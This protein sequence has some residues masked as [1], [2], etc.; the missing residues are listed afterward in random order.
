MGNLKETLATGDT[1]FL[2][3]KRG[4]KTDKIVDA[5][6]F[7]E[8]RDYFNFGLAPTVSM[9]E[10]LWRIWH[11]KPTPLE[12]VLASAQ[13]TFKS[14]TAAIST[15]YTL[16]LLSLMN[17]PH[18]ELRMSPIDEIFI[19]IQS[20]KL[21]TAEDAIYTRIQN[22]VD[23]SP[24]F[25][26]SFPRNMKLSSELHFPNNIILKPI[27]GSWNAIQSKNV[28]GGAI[29]EIN[30]MKVHKTSVELEH[31]DK[32]VWD[33]GEQAFRN[34]RNRV[35][36]RFKAIIRSGNHVGRI[37]IDSARRYLGDFT[38]RKTEEAKKDP[39]ILVIQR[40]LWDAKP[41]DY[42]GEEWFYVEIATDYRPARILTKLENAEQWSDE[43]LKFKKKFTD[44][45][46]LANNLNVIRVPESH[47]VDFEKDLE[48]AL[49]DYAAV[50]TKATGRFIPYPKQITAAQANFVKRTGGGSLFLVE[51]IVLK[52][53]MPWNQLIN[54]DYVEQLKMEGEFNWAFHLDASE[55]V[56][57]AAGLA[58]TRIID[59]KLIEKGYFYNHKTGELQR[60]ENYNM[61]VFCCD[62]V[63]RILAAPGEHINQLV[64][65]DIP[66]ELKH[67][68][69]I[70]WGTVDW[71][72]PDSILQWWREHGIKCGPKSV[73]KKPGAY[74]EYSHAIRDERILFPPHKTLDT[75]T[76]QLKR[77]TKGGEVKIDHSPGG[78][79][80]LSDAV[81]GSV[82]TCRR[83]FKAR[84][85]EPQKETDPQGSHQP[86]AH[87]RSVGGSA[88]YGYGGHRR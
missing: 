25:K 50:P 21:E 58:F 30:E 33:V 54:Y 41:F 29:S 12:V 81:A 35:V 14:T 40:P 2:Q 82:H 16:Y 60:V 43:F 53:D 68:L 69:A 49:R 73:D 10:D 52:K 59:T 51:E 74:F 70:R 61:P 1:T 48:T 23:A 84:I 79:K 37:I 83:F 72:Q 26:K 39:L 71:I 88:G 9:K 32:Q 3:R 46:W 38:D 45:N 5:V 28:V 4:F 11:V 78:S 17:D 62:G 66:V 80:D 44:A 63:L 67:H 64:L 42:V 77:I 22:G 15:A 18:A 6:Q 8:D 76:R 86:H 13:G 65:Q 85:V 27:P 56:R 55:G 47:R 19:I 87:R 20:F 31:T 36:G 24:Y 7:A 34:F 75:E 57:D